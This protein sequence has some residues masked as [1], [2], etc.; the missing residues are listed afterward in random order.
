M[1]E[2][3]NRGVTVLATE[4]TV[5]AGGVLFWPDGNIPSLFRFHVRLAVA[6]EASFILF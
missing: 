6:G 1:R 4:D 3:L 2:V 5:N